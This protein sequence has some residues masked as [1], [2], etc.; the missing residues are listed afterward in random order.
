MLAIQDLVVRYG[1]ITALR[2]VGLHVDE[3]EIVSVV[4]PNGAGKS[5]LLGAIAGV[6]P[7]AEGSITFEGRS[8]VGSKPEATA[9]LAISLVPEGR[10]IFAKLTVLEN[11]RLGM[12][13]RSRADRSQIDD[14]LERFPVLK[15]F[16]RS[17]AGKL[18][19][20]EQQQLAIARALVARP[21]LMLLDE[22]SLGLAP[23]IVE[24]VLQTLRELHDSGITIVLVEQFAAQARA[25]ADRTYVLGLGRVVLEVGRDDE[26]SSEGFEAAYLGARTAGEHS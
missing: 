13:T 6:V 24:E 17:S 26:I 19:G 4:G 9:R 7:V 21:R 25:I 14:A 15:R 12:S 11:L 2:S 3:G 10:H 8:L 20:G 22:P 23:M 5:S 18:S 16:L 1:R